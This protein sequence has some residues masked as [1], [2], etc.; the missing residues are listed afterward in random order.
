MGHN[1]R[2]DDG[3]APPT[4]CYFVGSRGFF[5]SATK[6]RA[7]HTMQHGRPAL[8]DSGEVEA[9][10]FHHLVPGGHKVMDKAL[11]AVLAGIYLGIRAQHRI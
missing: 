11:L 9:V 10:E 5:M 1:A 8:P 6:K 4:A 7:G 2:P 3:H